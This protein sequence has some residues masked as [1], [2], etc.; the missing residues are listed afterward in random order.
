MTLAKNG[1]EQIFAEMRVI[2]TFIQVIFIRVCIHAHTHIRTLSEKFM[3]HDPQEFKLHN[4]YELDQK[5]H[6]VMS[7]GC[8]INDFHENFIILYLC[9]W[10]N[11]KFSTQL[12]SNL[13]YCTQM[14]YDSF[15]LLN[16]LWMIHI[17]IICYHVKS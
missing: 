15:I 8:D 16:T 6:H 1:F 12:H 7:Y 13:L 2:S 11:V 10:I 3:A 5:H 17:F 9:E 14:K 4:Y